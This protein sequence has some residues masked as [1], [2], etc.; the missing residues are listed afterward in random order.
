MLSRVERFNEHVKIESIERQNPDWDWREHW[1]LIG[2]DVVSLFPS[3]SASN[4]ARILREQV[5]K[6][7]IKWRNIDDTWLRL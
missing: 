1:M 4:T 6:S 5:R 3:L 2:R 7:P